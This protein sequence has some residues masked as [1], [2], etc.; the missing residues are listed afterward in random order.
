MTS[1]EE[2]GRGDSGGTPADSGLAVGIP[3]GLCLGTGVGVALG[4][5]V[6]DSV[7]TGLALGMPL[8]VCLGVA[9]GGVGRKR[10]P[11]GPER[12]G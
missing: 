5:T 11:E 7:G 12:D 1:G 10:T 9:I 3:V 2:H 4:L 8:G 6:F